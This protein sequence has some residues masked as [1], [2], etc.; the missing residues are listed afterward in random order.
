VLK[1][2]A[3]DDDTAFLLLAGKPLNE[4]IVWRGPSVLKY[5]KELEQTFYDYSHG[6]NGFEGADT[7]K[8]EIR[9]LRFK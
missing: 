1:V 4:P 9:N 8:S 2:T 3:E 6:V 7:W 5:L